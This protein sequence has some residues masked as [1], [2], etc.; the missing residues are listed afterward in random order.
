MDTKASGMVP[1]TL[2]HVIARTIRE[3][4]PWILQFTADLKDVEAAARSKSTEGRRSIK[5]P[6]LI[7]L[8][9]L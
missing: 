6:I 1:L 5:A 9:I 7:I 8:Y 3:K 2:L 4:F